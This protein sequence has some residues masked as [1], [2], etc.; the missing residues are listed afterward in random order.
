MRTFTWVLLGGM[1][2]LVTS[3]GLSGWI[4]YATL[5]LEKEPRAD[6]LALAAEL[7]YLQLQT[8]ERRGRILA[9]VTSTGR[10][11]DNGKRAGY[12]LT[13]L[14]RA[15]W[16]FTVNGYEVDVASP[17]GGAPE[18]VV[19]SDDVT[20]ADYAFLNDPDIRRKLATTLPLAQVDPERYAAV[21]FVGGKGTM[22][23]FPHNPDIARIVSAIDARNGVVG[24]VCHGPAAL[25]GVLREDG[26]PWLRDR[27][28]TGFTN[29]EEL[30]LIPEARDRFPFL[31]QDELIAHG[32]TFHEAPMY[33]GHTIVDGRLVSGQNPWSTWEVAET[34]IRV[35]GHEPLPR[36]VTPEEV[37]VSLLHVYRREGLGA[38]IAL[39]REAP[40]ADKR[41]LL[42]HAVV[43]AMQWELRSA[44]QLQRLARV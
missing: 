8:P 27:Q 38:A 16:V 30:F 3:L 39:K 15:Y 17:M 11:P 42:M 20:D 40:R 21:Y 25:V 33:L 1:V 9:V 36:E 28:V 22:F 2:A 10:F 13:E 43:A 32:A 12:E 29:A 41:L 34:M 26:S 31:L 23:D 19:D 14:S 5:D 7:P 6:P 35:L 18:M 4:W 24:A 37:S 44:W